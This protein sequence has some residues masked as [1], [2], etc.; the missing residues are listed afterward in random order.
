MNDYAAL[1]GFVFSTIFLAISVPVLVGLYLFVSWV[2]HR[3]GRKFGIGS[4]GEFC[5]PIYGWVLLCRCAGLSAWNVLWFFVPVPLANLVWIAGVWSGQIG[6]NS[7]GVALAFVVAALLVSS[8]FAV[9]FWG[10]MAE[11]LGHSFWVYG[12]CIFWFAIPVYGLAFDSSTY[13]GEQGGEL[14]SG[15]SVY[16][17]SGEYKGNQLP[18]GNGGLVIGRSPSQAQLVLTSPEISGAHVRVWPDQRGGGLWVQDMQSLNGTYYSETGRLGQPERWTEVSEAVLLT[19]G[20][21]F[22]VGDSV[23]EFMVS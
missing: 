10:T 2:H 3:I 19:A 8:V 18:V 5:I 15:P 12:L 16:C 9:F 6:T 23:A 17:V 20:A 22:R 13:A 14:P 21:H 1:P 4:F 7:Y 11:R